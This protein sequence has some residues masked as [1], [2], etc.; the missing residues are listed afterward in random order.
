MQGEL[1]GAGFAAQG[2]KLFSADATVYLTAQPDGNLV[3]YNT[4]LTHSHGVGASSAIWASGTYGAAN[5]PF[6]LVMQQ[7]GAAPPAAGLVQSMQLY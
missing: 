3:L 2:T 4:S 6:T 1:R 5:G 7:V